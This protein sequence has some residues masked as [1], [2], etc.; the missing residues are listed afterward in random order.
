VAGIDDGL[1]SERDAM[2][3]RANGVLV[4][5][6]VRSRKIRGSLD[7]IRKHEASP[8]RNARLVKGV[9]KCLKQ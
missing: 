8:R 2:A 3:P 6:S 9:A 1:L 4:L 7:D 5:D